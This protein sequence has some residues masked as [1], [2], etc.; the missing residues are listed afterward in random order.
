MLPKFCQKGAQ[1]GPEP[2]RGLKKSWKHIKYLKK[3]ISSG[4]LAPFLK[5]FS[6]LVDFWGPLGGPKIVKKIKKNRCQKLIFLGIRSWTHF[7]DFFTILG[8]PQGPPKTN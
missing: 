7:F 4:V 6:A 2:P 8:P 5:N 1:M 3:A